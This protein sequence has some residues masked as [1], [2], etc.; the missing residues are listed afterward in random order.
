MAST[1]KK[2]FTFAFAMSQP[3]F[4]PGMKG[5][6][7][8]IWSRTEQHGG[9]SAYELKWLNKEFRAETQVFT[10]EDILAAQRIDAF[11]AAPA[12]AQKKPARKRSRSKR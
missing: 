1:A 9:A 8:R 7:G 10:L 6:Q 5:I 4:V 11:A 12:G 3:L 2:K